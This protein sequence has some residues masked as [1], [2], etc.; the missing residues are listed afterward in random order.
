MSTGSKVPLPRRTS[1]DWSL[2]AVIVLW[3]TA[4]VVGW[5]FIEDYSFSE[6]PP[7]THRPV[8]RWPSQTA[9][10]RQQ[11]RPTMLLFLHPKCPCSR[12]TLHELERLLT[13]TSGKAVRA[14]DL[15][16]VATVP[17]FPDESW[18][19]SETVERVGQLAN[20]RLFIDPN[21]TEAARFGAVTSGLVMY[22]DAEGTTQYSGGI[23]MARGHE[24]PSVGGECVTKILRGETAVA[25]EMPAFGCRLCL[26]E[27]DHARALLD[28]SSRGA[29]RRA[30]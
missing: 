26:P 17:E 22:F 29:P 8:D 5:W 10:T 11:G 3:V 23:T 6:N 1:A 28:Q 27:P 12:A 30:T 19:R 25:H 15:I 9:L 16:V 20:A 14:V 2:Y 24:G 13:S 18:L 7:L 21:G 4:V